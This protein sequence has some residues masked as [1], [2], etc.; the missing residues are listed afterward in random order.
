VLLLVHPIDASV[1]CMHVTANYHKLQ[2]PSDSVNCN[3]D[4][5]DVDGETCLE[6]AEQLWYIVA[7]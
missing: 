5:A 2:N 7:A 3:K 6:Q 4:H 1:T